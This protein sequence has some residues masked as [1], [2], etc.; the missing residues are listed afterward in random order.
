M[1]ISLKTQN[2][3]DT[4][5]RPDELKMK[6]DQNVDASVHLQ[7]RNKILMGGKGWEGLGRKGGGG[8]GEGS[9]IR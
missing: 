2:T 1:D 8:G 4:I 6:E 9:R 7:R 5:H 3:Q